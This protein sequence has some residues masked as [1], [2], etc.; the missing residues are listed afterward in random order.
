M[1]SLNYFFPSQR[2]SSPAS[3]SI[4]KPPRTPWV[5]STPLSTD[6][7]VWSSQRNNASAPRSTTSRPIFPSSSPSVSP[8]I[9]AL[10]PRVKPS[11]NVCSI[12]GNP[13]PEI[14]WTKPPR[15]DQS[16]SI[17]VSA[18]VSTST[19]PRSTSTTTSCKEATVCVLLY[20]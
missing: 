13:S 14:L 16:S 15:P 1:G 5:V 2:S 4:F 20:L 19:S 18:R 11:P 12:T 17:P 7:V 6:V 8:P 3:W 10:K 9:S